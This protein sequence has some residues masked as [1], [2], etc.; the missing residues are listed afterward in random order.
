M[1][2]VRLIYASRFSR[3]VGPNDV[4]NIVKVSR[5]H[6]EAMGVTGVL[7]YDPHFFLQCL[8]GDRDAVN[9]LYNHI[10]MDDRH[11]DVRLLEYSDVDQ[12]VFPSWF[13]AYVRFDELTKPILLKY[14]ATATFDPY[15]MSA[16]QA[17]GFIQEIAEERYNFLEKER[18]KLVE[19]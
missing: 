3:G 7:C 17:L 10:I 12:R 5:K 18:Q 4:Q 6:N 11:Q 14:G 16:R 19:K 2:M 1:K 13:M 15:T 8:E 9:E